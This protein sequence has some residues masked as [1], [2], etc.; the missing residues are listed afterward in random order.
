MTSLLPYVE[1]ARLYSMINSNEPW[2]S[3]TNQAVFHSVV[4]AYL[5][6]NV[7]TENSTIGS[8]GAAHYAGNSQVLKANGH[9]GI[10]YIRD[11]SSNTILA[12]EV[13]GGFMAWGDPENRRDPANGFGTAPNQFGS[14]ATGRGGVN[15]LMAD[16]AVRFIS[17]N[18][19][20][21]TLKA[22]ASPAG[23]EPIGAF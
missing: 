4:P 22:L 14:P 1:Q 9:D 6:P 17:D 7:G 2:T 20:P 8:L 12:G 13:S 11:G 16:G 3:P 5:N 21:Q 23:K 18:I 19:N 10:A 15:M